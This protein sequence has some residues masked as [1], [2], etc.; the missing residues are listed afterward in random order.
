MAT[1][2]PG[3]RGQRIRSGARLGTL[4][5]V[6]LSAVALGPGLARG[7]D[8][9]WIAADEIV[10][11]VADGQPVE[12]DGMVIIGDLDLHE[13]ERV[14]RTFTC[15]RCTFG[16]SIRASNV[17]FERM[18]DLSGSTVA[19]DV[20]FSGAIFRDAFLMR[21]LDGR[22]AGV[23][24]PVSFSLASFG[25]RANFEGA[26]FG[27]DVDFRVAQF[28]GEASF[29][30]AS[31]ARDV[32]FD[33]ATFGA[34]TRFNASPTTD[35]AIGGTARFTAATFQQKADFRQ[36]QFLGQVLFD[37]ASFE[38]ADF[39]LARFFDDVTFD[40]AT[41]EGTGV[42]RS[43]RFRGDLK[44]RNVILRGPTD[45]QTA[46]IRGTADFS[47]VSASDRFVLTGLSLRSSVRLNG[48]TAPAIEMDLKRLS[49]IEGEGVRI[50]VL[51]MIE[52]GARGRGDLGLA[53]EA[54]YR[55]SQMQTT[56]AQGAQRVAAQI[57]E[58]VG[59]YLV[60]PLLPIRAMIFL[61]AI[62]TAIR[63]IAQVPSVSARQA[64]WDLNPSQ[65]VAAAAAVSGGHAGSGNVVDSAAAGSAADPPDILPLRISKALAAVVRAGAGTLRASVRLR[66]QDIPTRRENDLWAY[67]AALLVFAEWLAWKVLFALFL[68]GLAN[69]NPTFKELVEA[70]A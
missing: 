36:R 17:I 64:L 14:A 63:A 8:A 61:F 19:G 39:T 38:V 34:M 57:S 54:A 56:R 16:G 65:P 2:R 27:S 24:G 48:V 69:S 58:N 15:T 4:A 13:V 55:R 11:T 6:A 47:Q 31:F 21:A 62:G 35:A 45:F 43:T 50:E 53:N 70:V 25:G 42:F 28:G 7:A 37:G 51:E 30:D 44:F 46:S 1:R 52:A 20:D 23:T 59:G 49:D 40:G 33:S 12:L 41:I 18:V 10:R 32:L 67:G 26:A 66:P 3:T 29:A 9:E 22:S 5:A 68:I 60:Q